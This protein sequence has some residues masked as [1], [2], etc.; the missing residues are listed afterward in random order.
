MICR[1][2]FWIFIGLYGIAILLWLVGTYGWFGAERDPLSGV[3]L[4]ILGQPWAR[5][6]DILPER[7][8]PLG[9][10]AV[11]AINATII[12]AVCRVVRR[13]A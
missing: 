13:G 7:L 2:I 8:W 3:F 12:Y 5:W 6:V 4:V 11:P 9:G 10:A 1:T